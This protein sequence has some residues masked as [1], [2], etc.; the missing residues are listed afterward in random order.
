MNTQYQELF[1]LFNEIGAG[2]ERLTALATKKLE[3][4]QKDDLETLNEIMNQEQA[5]TLAFRGM[6]RKRETLLGELGLS[7]TALTALTKACPAELQEEAE[8]AVQTLQSRYRDY[9]SYADAARQALENGLTEIDQ[10]LND[11]G[12]NQPEGPGYQAPETEL[13]TKMRTDFRA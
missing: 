13:P 8:Q 4:V 3:A 5:E 12:G 7:A 11:L 10:V 2:L 1:A 9:R 6:E